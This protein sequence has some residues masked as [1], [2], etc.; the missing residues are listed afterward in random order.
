MPPEMEQQDDSVQEQTPG[1]SQQDTNPGERSLDE[2]LASEQQEVAEI[3]EANAAD[4]GEEAPA[5]KKT[6]S[7]GEEAG[8]EAEDGEE[9]P[10][11]YKPNLKF[12]VQDKEHEFHKSL[13]GLVNEETE[14]VLRELHEKAMGLDIVKPKLEATRQQLTQVTQ[15]HQSTISEVGRVLGYLNAKDFDSFFESL[16]VPPHEVAKW[17]AEKIEVE[18]LP[19]EQKAVYTEREQLR[20]RLNTLEGT[21]QSV[22]SQHADATGQAR[23]AALDAKLASDETVRSIAAGFDERNGQ[24]AFKRAV[25]IHAAHVFNAQK[26]D[27]TPDEAVEDYIKT[28]GLTA[29]AQSKVTPKP[30]VQATRRVVA[31]PKVKTIPNYGGSQASAL[32]DRKPKS[33][34]DIKKMRREK[35]GS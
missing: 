22:T 26:R 17:L 35:Y 21:V 11:E 15:Q 32:P 18:R 1:D 25:A 2:I 6:A 10:G 12:K 14:P 5:G 30:G 19:P 3:D 8:E 24:N 20:K 7:E 29:P 27:L 9:S 34:E 16:N 28:M 31:R 23:L 13:H 4:E 33:I